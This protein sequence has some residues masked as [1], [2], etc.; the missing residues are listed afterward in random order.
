M[1]PRSVPLP[2]PSFLQRGWT[3]LS[4]AN[5]VG[6]PGSEYSSP[7]AHS[8]F[9]SSSSL[10]AARHES[11]ARFEAAV[12]PR[13]VDDGIGPPRIDPAA[14]SNRLGELISLSH[15]ELFGDRFSELSRAESGEVEAGRSHRELFRTPWRAGSGGMGGDGGWRGSGDGMDWVGAEGEQGDAEC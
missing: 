7:G 3:P 2:I 10:S 11:T 9:P 5:S 8:R 12:P 6:S 13:F 1:E 4:L 14:L 15:R